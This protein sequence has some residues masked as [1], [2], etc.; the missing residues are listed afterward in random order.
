[1]SKAQPQAIKG[2]K[3]FCNLCCENASIQA[4]D[5]ALLVVCPDHVSYIFREGKLID[6]AW[7]PGVRQ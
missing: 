6:T 7:V 2:A 4:C 5:E 1:M 3:F